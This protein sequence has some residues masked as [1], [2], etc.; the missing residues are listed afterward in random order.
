MALT[1][2]FD[3]PKCVPSFQLGRQHCLYPHCSQTLPTHSFQF[4]YEFLL[5][6]KHNLDIVPYWS[7]TNPQICL[8]GFVFVF[9]FL[10]VCLFFPHLETWGNRRGK[11]GYEKNQFSERLQ[12]LSRSSGTLLRANRK[13]SRSLW[14]SCS[15]GM[16]SKEQ[17]TESP[18]LLL[19]IGYVIYL[20]FKC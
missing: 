20:H 8:Q 11:A 14:E 10:F 7:T 12:S 15:G 13:L 3:H 9:C 19:F 18:V 2:W 6:C 1:A 17:S 4:E 16:D 5:K